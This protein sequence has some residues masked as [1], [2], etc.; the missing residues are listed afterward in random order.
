MPTQAKKRTGESPSTKERTK[1]KIDWL[2]QHDAPASAGL[3]SCLR[4]MNHAVLRYHAGDTEL[5]ELGCVFI[6][7][8][9][10]MRGEKRKRIR[11][12]SKL[13]GF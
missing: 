9:G 4:C 13:S 10:E 6:N 8:G 5:P 7:F 3:N 1:K 11:S 2:T 12:E